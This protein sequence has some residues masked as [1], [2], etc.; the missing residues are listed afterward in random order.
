MPLYS[1]SG[2][3]LYRFSIV[4]YSPNTIGAAG[5][6]STMGLGSTGCTLLSRQLLSRRPNDSTS[7]G[8]IFL[9]SGKNMIAMTIKTNARILQA[10]ADGQEETSGDEGLAE[11]SDTGLDGEQLT[12]PD[13]PFVVDGRSWIVGEVIIGI[14]MVRICVN[15]SVLGPSVSK[16]R[17][18]CRNG[19]RCHPRCRSAR[20]RAHVFTLLWK[21][22]ERGGQV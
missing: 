5:G 20:S 8:K 21:Q 14:G 10:T 2:T 18:R 7:H 19:C 1:L 3:V 11:Q 9:Q 22:G 12:D 13:S 15:V 16:R 6:S 4:L 17:R